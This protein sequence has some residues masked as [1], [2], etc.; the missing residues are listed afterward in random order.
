MAKKLNTAEYWDKRSIDRSV[1]AERSAEARAKEVRAVYDRAQ[2]EVTADINKIYRTYAKGEGIDVDKLLEKMSVED[3]HKF[4]LKMK[5]DG[6]LEYITSNY[7][8]RITRLEMIKGELYSKVR[9]IADDENAIHTA[10]HVDTINT[11]FNTN[12][13]DTAQGLN[14]NIAF[15]GLNT[16]TL[17]AMLNNTWQGAN[18][19]QRIWGNTNLLATTVKDQLGSALLTGKSPRRVSAE[20]AEKFDVSRYV[21]NRLVRTETNYFQNEAEAQSNEAMGLERYKFV[22]TLDSRTSEV[23]QNRDDKVFLLKDRSTGVN[24]PPMHPQCRSTTRVYLGDEFEPK[25]RTARNAEGKN[26]EVENMSYRQWAKANAVQPVQPS[27]IPTPKP[28]TQ[29]AVTVNQTKSG[30]KIKQSTEKKNALPVEPTIRG[31]HPQLSSVLRDG[32]NDVYEKYPQAFDRLD[33]V[34]MSKTMGQSGNLNGVYTYGGQLK[35]RTYVK[36]ADGTFKL[37]DLGRRMVQG[38]VDIS[39][40]ISVRV[41]QARND[42]QKY[43]ER[44]TDLNEKGWW[45]TKNPKAVMYHELGH[46]LEQ[47][48]NLQEA[49]MY[50]LYDKFAENADKVYLLN[51]VR[52]DYQSITKVMTRH[53]IAGDLVTDTMKEAF[54]ND[55]MFN[56]VKTNVSEYA[57]KSHAETFAELFAKVMNGDKDVVTKTF[58]KKLNAK[59][60]ELKLL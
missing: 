39:Q 54:P 3:T 45:A 8:S 38:N 24:Y 40:K 12:V 17:D 16:Q 49:G 14:A 46:S 19:S 28:P 26:V 53:K 47:T 27:V 15:T 31:V 33:R 55:S 58:E 9:S 5:A 30:V 23:C 57:K 41:P 1:L 56:A 43:S 34:L 51:D 36:N 25:T 22:A 18:Y 11:A 60:T 37:D 20:I 13:F 7:Q 42:L 10:T 50:Q 35:N 4:W 21:A 29:I 44:V 48:M 52:E 6:N 59:L 2:R 32:M